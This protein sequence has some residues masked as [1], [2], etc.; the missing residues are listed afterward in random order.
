MTNQE[1]K[2]RF[3]STNVHRYLSL[4]GVIEFQFLDAI[5]K[6]NIEHLPALGY[7]AFEKLSFAL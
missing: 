1:K 4:N 3:W 7:L 5:L 2:K 6:T